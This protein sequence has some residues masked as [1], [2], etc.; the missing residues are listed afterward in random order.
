LTQDEILPNV[1]L[2]IRD[3]EGRKWDDILAND[4]GINPEVVRPRAEN[5]Y[6]K[7]DIDYDALDSYNAAILTGGAAELKRERLDI[8]A[9]QR[10]FRLSEA[11]HD[12]GLARATAQEANKTIAAL[13][14]FISLQKEKLKAVK[15]NLGKEPPKDSAAKILRYEARIDRA[16]A[17]KSRALRRLRR[18][19]KRIDSALKLV[20]NYQNNFIPKG[21]AEMNDNDVKPLFT[22]N[23]NIMDTENAFKPVSFGDLAPAADIPRVSPA[24]RPAPAMTQPEAPPAAEPASRPMAPISGADVKISSAEHARQGGAYYF[25]LLLLIGLSIFTL[26]LY[27]KKMSPSALPDI[28]AIMSEKAPVQT[29]PEPV[30][31]PIPELSPP[32]PIPETLP[33]AAPAP[34][35][36]GNPFIESEPAPTAGPSPEIQPAASEPEPAIEEPEPADIVEDQVAEYELATEEPE[37]ADIVEDQAAEYEPADVGAEP[38]SDGAA[39]EYE[40][41]DGA[42]DPGPFVEDDSFGTDMEE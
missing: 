5:K 27:Q 13:D 40:E 30:P 39:L 8:A 21:E 17:K 35:L 18:A 31:E 28:A 22:E 36:A 38:E 41:N 20:N 6:R 16:D 12:I 7:L 4:F 11:E 33:D 10:E 23:P 24:V 29:E 32:E 15:K 14:E 2:V 9:K 19:E 37:P 42:L 26:Y 25:M 1:L 3:R 34:A